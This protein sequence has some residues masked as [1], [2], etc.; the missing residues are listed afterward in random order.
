MFPLQRDDVLKNVASL[1]GG[2]KSRLALAKIIL[3][4]QHYW[5]WMKPT[6]H[7]ILPRGSS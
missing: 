5:L 6:N 2:E 7:L 1:S 3:N 4:V